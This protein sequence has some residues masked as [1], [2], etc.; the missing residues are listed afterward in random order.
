MG[1]WGC[2]N[3]ENDDALDWVID[4]EE[5]KDLSFVVETLD[6]VIESAEDYVDAWESSIALA[7]AEVIAAL[8]G[9]PA[10]Q[11]PEEVL[12]WIDKQPNSLDSEAIRKA[13]QAVKIILADSE[14][15]ELWQETDEFAQWEAVVIDIQTRLA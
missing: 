4:L 3:F 6:A 10:A 2:G 8:A 9:H 14:L 5:A 15:K 12:A 7:A 13:K 11:L 1:A